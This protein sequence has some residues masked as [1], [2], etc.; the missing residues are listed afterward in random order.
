MDISFYRMLFAALSSAPFF[1]LRRELAALGAL[2]APFYVSY[3]LSVNTVGITLAVAF[4]YTA[5]AWVSLWERLRGRG[6]LLPAALSVAGVYLL[7]GAPRLEGNFFIALAPGLLYAGVII[8]SKELLKRRS[9]EELLGANVYAFI[10]AMPMTL[11]VDPDARALLSGAYLGVVCTTLAYLLFYSGLREL[12][13]WYA[14]VA[15]TLEPT[16]ASLW[17]ALLGERLG[18]LELSGLALI[19]TSQLLA[20]FSLPRTRTRTPPRTRFRI[21]TLLP[22]SPPWLP[23]R[24][25]R[26]RPQAPR[27]SS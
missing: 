5:P 1:R 13:A 11:F 10:Y 25:S 4:L 22:P 17:G 21:H 20:T 8:Y 7:S 3:V 16:L 2:Y 15:A 6:S 12:P 9:P 14:S 26:G 18:P 23:A 27:G 24:I 19:L